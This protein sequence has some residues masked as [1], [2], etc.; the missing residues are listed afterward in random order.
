MEGRD[1]HMTLSPLSE[2][3]RKKAPK[4]ENEINSDIESDQ[5]TE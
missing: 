4:A 1:M 2:L 3:E 5:I